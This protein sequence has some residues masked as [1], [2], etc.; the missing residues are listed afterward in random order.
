MPNFCRT[1]KPGLAASLL[2]AAL[3]LL[4]PAANAQEQPVWR[5]GTSSIGKL[6]YADGFARFDYVN[7]DAPKGGELRLSENG[8]FDTFNTILSKGEAATGVASLV[9]DTLLKS[10][11]DEITT[12]YGLLAE[13]VSY[14]DDISS[15]TFRLRAEAKWADGTPVT[16]EDVIFS[17]NMVKEHNP[18][19]SNYYRHVVAAE[20]T[21]ERDVTFRFDEKN[22][23]ELPNI[24][25]QLSIVPKHWWEGPDEK[26]NKRDISRTTLEP[27]MGSGPYKIASFQPGGSIRFEL[28]DDYWGK[29]LNVNVGQYN[30]RTINY[31]FFSDRNVEFEAFRSG[32]VDFYRDQSASHWAQAYDFPAMKDGRVIREEIENPL[33][34]MGVMQA[35]VPNM[36]RD[37]FKDQ[38]VR[39]ALNYAFDF[40]DLNRNLA[41]NAYQRVD[42]YFWGSELASSKLPEGREKAILEELKD[43]VPPE[44]FT[45][46][47]TNPING[48]PQKVR[49]N[50]RKALDLFKEAGYE[51]KGNRLVNTKTGEPFAFELLLANPSYERTVT[52]FINSAKKI[53]IDARIRTVDD[54]QYTN[55][56]RSFDYDMIY[57][58][59]G[60][61]LVPGNEQIDYWGSSSVNQTG[62]RNYAGIADPAID[63]LIR[64]II[65]APNR[66]EL[67]ATTRALDRVLLAHHYVVPLFYSKA[68]RVAYWNHLAHLK[69]LPYYGTGFPDAWWSKN[70]TA[71]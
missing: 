39:E 68:I 47:Y 51:L 38:R 49:T 34:A 8:T 45:T 44:V 18:L 23:H 20:K 26:G 31:A 53:G 21:G 64:R 33:R 71:K 13:G 3:L 40:E 22:N 57:G 10:A 54:S 60:Q 66:E 6:K 59:W 15:A 63:E 14:P 58:I 62:S 29:N 70:A 9:F 46:P 42:S 36:R 67:V 7:P 48:D 12:S 43:K 37:K 50:L 55:R 19:L 30:F 5:H 17:L 27:V 28:R 4:T 2:T 11:E 69:E 16:P 56:V 1:V 65:F 24:L 25:G 52:P 32:N 41:Y 35:F 61:T